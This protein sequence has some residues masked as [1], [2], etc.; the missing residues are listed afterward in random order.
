MLPAVRFEALEP[1]QHQYQGC[2]KRCLPALCFELKFF[3]VRETVS[4]VLGVLLHLC[5][6]PLKQDDNTNSSFLLLTSKLE[7]RG[8]NVELKLNC[9]L[10]LLSQCGG[11]K[12]LTHIEMHFSLGLSTQG[13]DTFTAH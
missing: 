6:L 8:K 7:R 2:R 9:T 12:N 10:T 5:L 3:E 13:R 1:K 4:T 11:K